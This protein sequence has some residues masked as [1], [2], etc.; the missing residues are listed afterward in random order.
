MINNIINLNLPVQY[1]EEFEVVTCPLQYQAEHLLL[2]SYNKNNYY[3]KT[4]FNLWRI[5]K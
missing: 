2:Y 4:K 3:N 1:I 5:L